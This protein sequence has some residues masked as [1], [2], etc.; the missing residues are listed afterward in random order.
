MAGYV[1]AAVPLTVLGLW[2]TRRDYRRLGRLSVPAFVAL[3][4]MFFVPH[5]A[6]HAGI[7]Y[8]M[9]ST[10]ARW[11]GLG[12]GALGLGLCVRGIAVFRSVR[13]VFCFD[14]GTLTATGPYRW[15]R[16]P[17]YVG[18]GLFIVGFAIAGWT[19]ACI[20][21]LVLYAIIVHVM[22]RVEE[23]HLTR[24]FG[25]AYEEFRRRVPR[26]VGGVRA[27]LPA[28]SGRAG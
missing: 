28:T 3:L 7:D 2:W 27:P 18:W 9:P 12:I 16:N 13:K 10:G 20:I 24:V 22:V 17:Q 8:R 6:L 26:Y 14:H 4:V 25:A 23:E 21:P 1:I 15:S 19:R 11:V 5:L